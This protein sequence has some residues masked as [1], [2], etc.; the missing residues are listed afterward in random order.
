MFDV[1]LFSPLQEDLGLPE[2]TYELCYNA[3]CALIGQGQLTEAY[4]KLQQAEGLYLSISL[5]SCLIY[6]SIF[7]LIF[8]W[9]VFCLFFRALQDFTVR[10]FC[11]LY[12]FSKMFKCLSIVFIVTHKTPGDA[13]EMTMSTYTLWIF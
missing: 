12:Y 10:R 6:L 4:N 8:N 11:E 3:A 9:F 1:F 2:S 7:A 5:L 13:L